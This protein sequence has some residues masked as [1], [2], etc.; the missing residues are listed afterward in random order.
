MKI[1][2]IDIDENYNATLALS[3]GKDSFINTKS[4]LKELIQ[5]ENIDEETVLIAGL[6]RNFFI[7]RKI[8]LPDISLE[9]VKEALS[10]RVRKVFSFLKEPF[11]FYMPTPN[12][13]EYLAIVSEKEEIENVA[14]ILK[15]TKGKLI[16]ITLTGLILSELTEENTTLIIER[17]DY[18]EIIKKRQGKIDEY[19][20]LKKEMEVE[21]IETPTE[22]VYLCN[23]VN[24]DSECMRLISENLV[25]LLEFMKRHKEGFHI[26]F[27]IAPEFTESLKTVE[28]TPS[29]LSKL[30]LFSLIFFLVSPYLYFYKSLDQLKKTK[31]KMEK[32]VKELKRI[33]KKQ[34]EMEKQL[35][36][37][38]TLIKPYVLDALSEIGRLLGNKVEVLSLTLNRDKLKLT[39]YSEKAA[40]IPAILEKSPI[41]SNVK[42]SGAIIKAGKG[43][44]RF[45][46]EA[47]VIR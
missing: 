9:N 1:A 12:K 21:E 13:N 24:S 30:A 8:S 2:F 47:T 33:I 34:E 19:N 6:S 18:K 26:C 16:G 7:S 27:N 40:E 20:I 22:Q 38:Q 28:T 3:N 39:G 10:Y 29:W 25:K 11:F 45:T 31:S 32:E 5:N 15:E 36:S 37:F 43:R 14:R 4:N 35:K 44:E 46:I 23:L 41:F 42:L 17:K